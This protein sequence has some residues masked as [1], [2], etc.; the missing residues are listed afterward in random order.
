VVPF[1][2]RVSKVPLL[3]ANELRPRNLT[4]AKS[5]PCGRR[6]KHCH[7]SRFQELES[8]STTVFRQWLDALSEISSTIETHLLDGGHRQASSSS[9][10]PSHPFP[11]TWQVGPQ[12]VRQGRIARAEAFQEKGASRCLQVAQPSSLWFGV[13]TPVFPT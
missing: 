1:P 6:P 4:L 10:R 7:L 5:H 8:L 3:P 13:I 9:E 11:G 2:P 12:R